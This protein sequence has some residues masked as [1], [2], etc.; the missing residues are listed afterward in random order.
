MAPKA[1][2]KFTF[3]W[4]TLGERQAEL[5][6]S[7]LDN[8][9]SFAIGPAGT[10]K[11]LVAT[12]C[13][14]DALDKGIKKNGVDRIVVTRPLV[15]VDEQ[16][17]YLPGTL[18]EKI[19]PFLQPVIDLVKSANHP[20]MQELLYAA[21]SPMQGLAIAMMR[22]I[23]FEN[24]FVIIDEAQN[25]TASQFEMILTRVGK[26]CKMVITGDPSQCD[27]KT[28]KKSGLL[29]A[30][31]LMSNDPTVG[32]IRFTVDDVQRS[33]FVGRVIRAYD[34]DRSKPKV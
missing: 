3:E 19:D 28:P 20:R 8:T 1:P 18:E 7:I 32:V 27:L 14:L 15:T 12:Y 13:A 6:T 29:H 11:T 24:C 33:D 9:V 4:E 25:I 30:I 16:V 34:A 26:N 21:D 5:K 2:G 22:G 31:G 23:T 10:G 17:G